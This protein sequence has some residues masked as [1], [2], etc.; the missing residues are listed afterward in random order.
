MS[1]ATEFFNP[2]LRPMLPEDVLAVMAIEREVYPF[3]WTEGIFHDCIR[4]GYACLVLE[5]MGEIVGYGVMSS[6]AGEAHILNVAVNKRYQGRGYGHL[7]MEH[8]LD[9]AMRLNVEAVFLEVRPS[10]KIAVALYHR[11]GFEQV[12]LRRNYYPDHEGK[13]DALIMAR[14]LVRPS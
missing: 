12:G 8:F 7:L 11:L 9:L 5:E 4:V 14:Q 3:C 6:G 2:H 10:N 1:A 13:E